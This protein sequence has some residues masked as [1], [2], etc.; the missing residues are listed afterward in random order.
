MS[1]IL[2]RCLVVALQTDEG[3]PRDPWSYESVLDSSSIE[4]WFCKGISGDHHSF[5]SKL[6]YGHSSAEMLVNQHF[7][8]ARDHFVPPLWNTYM[9]QKSNYYSFLCI[10]TCLHI[11]WH[12]LCVSLLVVKL[13]IT[14][15]PYLHK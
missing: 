2:H 1:R 9:V 4:R 15:L 14:T 13:G 11:T 3:S 6:V 7:L 12:G 10:I 8:C 5:D